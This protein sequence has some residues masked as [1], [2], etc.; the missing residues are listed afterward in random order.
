MDGVPSEENR[1][2]GVVIKQQSME[3]ERIV[4]GEKV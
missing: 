3:E 4:R 1:E 2:I